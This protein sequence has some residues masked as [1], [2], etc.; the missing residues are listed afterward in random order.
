MEAL[1]RLGKIRVCD[2]VLFRRAAE[3]EFDSRFRQKARPNERASDEGGEAF[4]MK[5]FNTII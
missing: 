3:H 5:I 4:Y 1:T 2:K